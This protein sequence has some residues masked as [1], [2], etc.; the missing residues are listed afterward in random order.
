MTLRAQQVGFAGHVVSAHFFAQQFGKCGCSSS[1]CSGM[2]KPLAVNY[3]WTT[4]AMSGFRPSVPW[5]PWFVFFILEPFQKARRLYWSHCTY[6]QYHLVIQHSHGK[7]L[8]NGGINGKII[9]KWAIFHGYVAL[10]NQMSLKIMEIHGNLAVPQGQNLNSKALA[11]HP[12]SSP[13]ASV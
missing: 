2:V 4:S 3:V 9:Y 13:T 6:I 7:S 1:N 12:G 5:N 10:N 8:I 11:I